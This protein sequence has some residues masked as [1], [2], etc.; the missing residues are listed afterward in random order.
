MTLEPVVA[1]APPGFEPVGARILSDIAI[2]PCDLYI[3]RGPRPVLYAAG[4][5]DLR[6]IIAR[7]QHGMSFLVRDV[8]LDLL[9]GALAASLPDV[10]ENRAVPALERSRTAYSI[11]AKVLAPIFSQDRGLDHDRLMLALQTVDAF[12]AALLDDDDLV[13]AM[14]ATMQRHMASHT[15]AF[16]TAIYGVALARAIRLGNISQVEDV[17][18]GGLLHDV[19]KTRVP[20]AILDKP[21]SLD[22]AEWQVMRGHVKAGYDIVVRALGYAPSYA[23]IIAEHH[24]RCDGSGYP[25][26]RQPHQ[27]AFDSQLVALVDA[28]DAL[29]SRRS[30]KPAISAFEALRVMSVTMRGQFNEELLREFI[31]VLGGWS[32]LNAD[33]SAALQVA[34]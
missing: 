13:W 31:K 28:Y 6:K 22:V 8:D 33:V 19:G 1:S 9:R 34:G 3:W 29:T 4:G 27:I 23:H 18:R 11:A 2:L 25:A 20:K 7:T 21:S 16:N 17:A 10:L 24:E 12:T 32:T 15:H 5:G 26:G 14:V 30:Y